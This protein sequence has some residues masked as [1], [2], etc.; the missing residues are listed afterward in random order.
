MRLT[1]KTEKIKV[2]D[3]NNQPV[4]G[5][6]RGVLFDDANQTIK[7]AYE[8]RTLLL[9]YREAKYDKQPVSL[10]IG[11]NDIINVGWFFQFFSS[12]ANTAKSAIK[13][14]ILNFDVTSKRYPEMPVEKVQKFHLLFNSRVD[15]NAEPIDSS[16]LDCTTED[17][18][19]LGTTG[20]EVLPRV[21]Y[22]WDFK[23][24]N[25][26]TPITGETTKVSNSVW[27]DVSSNGV[28][29]D[30][31]QLTIE[32]LQKINKINQVV[33]SSNALFTCPTA[34]TDQALVSDINEG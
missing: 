27:C 20:T 24:N 2:L 1:E 30:S 17:G 12:G 13:D 6:K 19:I 5:Q 14:K 21:V 15:E 33:S 16:L 10:K 4:D 11:A 7:D 34:V 23:E 31:T 3:Y 9:R 22:N 25:I 28:Y 32:V 18:K 29:C 26:V 8:Y